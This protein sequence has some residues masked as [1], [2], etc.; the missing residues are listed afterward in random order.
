MMMM[1]TCNLLAT[2]SLYYTVTSLS[3]SLSLSLSLSSNILRTNKQI[4]RG[5]N[6]VSRG[7]KSPPPPWNKPWPGSYRE[8]DLQLLTDHS[9]NVM[10]TG[11]QKERE[12]ASDCII[13]LLC[14]QG[15]LIFYGAASWREFSC[16]ITLFY[17]YTFYGVPAEGDFH[18]SSIYSAVIAHLVQ[19]GLYNCYAHYTMLH[20]WQTQ[21]GAYTVP[22]YVLILM[23]SI[24]AKKNFCSQD[25]QM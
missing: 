20:A 21:H 4:S 12:G 23:T 25:I 22:S 17:L 24:K 8:A 2:I 14:W 6:Q 9:Y 7:G 3:F 18:V 16:V 1:T 15:L 11:A 19:C 13:R 10:W 5:G